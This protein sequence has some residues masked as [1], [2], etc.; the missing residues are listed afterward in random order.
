MRIKGES[1]TL[2]LMLQQGL[3]REECQLIFDTLKK[4]QRVLNFYLFW[5]IIFKQ[6]NYCFYIVRIDMVELI[7]LKFRMRNFYLLYG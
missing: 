6:F 1:D 3:D 4:H 5:T 2:A 7:G